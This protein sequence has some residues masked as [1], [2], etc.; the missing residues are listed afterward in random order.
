MDHSGASFA[1]RAYKFSNLDVSA[2]ENPVSGLFRSFRMEAKLQ[3]V[4]NT[5]PKHTATCC[6]SR[7][8]RSSQDN[9]SWVCSTWLDQV[10]RAPVSVSRSRMARSRHPATAGVRRTHPATAH[11][12]EEIRTFICQMR[13][14]NPARVRKA[15]TQSRLPQRNSW[16]SYRSP[17]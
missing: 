11:W 1:Y 3:Q 2:A 14:P 6:F 8:W 15:M 4:H 13:I 7:S 9:W 10:P 5:A 17:L 12:F 16:L